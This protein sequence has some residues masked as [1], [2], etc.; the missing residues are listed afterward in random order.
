MAHEVSSVRGSF[1]F[2]IALSFA[3]KDKREKIR[4]I[5][6]MLGKRLG[7][8]KV[9]FDEYFEHEFGGLNADIY[10]Q[11]VYGKQSRLVVPCIC[12]CYSKTTWTEYE[13][14]A[15]RNF[16]SELKNDPVGRCRFFPIRV[17]EGEIEIDGLFPNIDV[18]LDV[19]DRNEEEIVKLIL[20]RHRHCKNGKPRDIP[21]PPLG[22]DLHYGKPFVNE[23][24][25]F[26]KKWRAEYI[27]S[28]NDKT[29]VNFEQTSR[30]DIFFL[31]AVLAEC[32]S[33]K[34]LSGNLLPEFSFVEK[35]PT[36]SV[37]ERV[38]FL[39]ISFGVVSERLLEIPAFLA[40]F[41]KAVFENQQ[42]T[43]VNSL[44]SVSRRIIWQTSINSSEIDSRLENRMVDIGLTPKR[45]REGLA[46]LFTSRVIGDWLERLGSEQWTTVQ[47]IVSGE[48]MPLSEIYVDLYAVPEP[49]GGYGLIRK[50]DVLKQHRSRLLSQAKREATNVVSLLHQLSRRT[51]IIGDPGSGKSTFTK[52]AVMQVLSGEIPDFRL[53]L[54]VN[55]GHL[56]REERQ[57]MC[58]TSEE[59][60]IDLLEHFVAP[61]ID[62]ADIASAARELAQYLK[63]RGDVFLILDGWDEVPSDLRDPVHL[64]IDRVNSFIP[65]IITSRP[66]G[67]PKALLGCQASIYE[68]AGLTSASAEKLVEVFFRRR[69]KPWL[70]L[71]ISDRIQKQ[72]SVFST[73][74]FLLTLQCVM[75]EQE[76]TNIVDGS[77][78][79]DRNAIYQKILELLLA[80]NR[81][82]LEPEILDKLAVLAETQS[83]SNG[84]TNGVSFTG[85]Q[86]SETLSN[87]SEAI[88]VCQSRVL[89]CLDDPFDTTPK[90]EHTYS[91]S[92]LTFGEFLAAKHIAANPDHAAIQ[93]CGLDLRRLE[94]YRFL[95]DFH[96]TRGAAEATRVLENRITAPDRYRF[97]FV[98]L[99][100]LIADKHHLVLECPW[101]NLITTQLW[102]LLC[103]EST[104]I[105]L[106]QE[107]VSLLFRINAKWFV[108]QCLE[109]P[110]AVQELARQRF[111]IEYGGRLPW[112]YLEK[113]IGP[114]KPWDAFASLADSSFK[115][116]SAFMQLTGPETTIFFQDTLERFQ[117]NHTIE[118]AQ[119]LGQMRN[120]EA[121]PS[122]VK[123]I[124]EGDPELA[125]QCVYALA[126]IKGKVAAHEIVSGLL[127]P[128]E[129]LG[130]S[131]FMNALR[132]YGMKAL[133]PDGQQRIIRRIAVS[134]PNLV[135]DYLDS[136]TGYPIR[137]GAGVIASLLVAPPSERDNDWSVITNAE[138][139]DG[140][141][142]VLRACEDIRIVESVLEAAKIE[143][144]PG[145]RAA[146]IGVA[147]EAGL[148]TAFQEWMLKEIPNQRNK[149]TVRTAL[150]SVSANYARRYPDSSFRTKLSELLVNELN[151][152]TLRSSFELLS[153][154]LNSADV[155]GVPAVAILGGFL[156]S[157]GNAAEKKYSTSEKFEVT[158]N[159]T[160]TALVRIGTEQAKSVLLNECRRL[161]RT[162]LTKREQFIRRSVLGGLVH[163]APLEVLN[164]MD[165][166]EEANAILRDWSSQ[167]GYLVF[168][169]YIFDPN[170]QPVVV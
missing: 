148:P 18:V 136:L 59:K 42:A 62:P 157:L 120:E 58:D 1:R 54:V 122:L 44:R 102:N 24:G 17:D 110:M 128:P 151:I 50:K 85:S 158:V 141:I 69:S 123:Q 166:C 139:R 29:T 163:M 138:I 107:I 155:A 64:A 115:P 22:L 130:S 100:Q 67:L 5:A 25:N 87:R 90:L 88:A 72:G 8:G 40:R 119:S 68:L 14:R 94:I 160:T 167:S 103:S 79:Q 168:D 93:K 52:W 47:G 131:P 162:P 96:G 111:V 145:I 21:T 117:L 114:G 82:R 33:G 56:R 81:V 121:V 95:L 13:W 134:P 38:K 170:G 126:T 74:P 150:L 2:E 124:K 84:A 132:S 101:C 77:F 36:E 31:F 140:A 152:L 146:L 71:E 118:D 129:A 142:R 104:P 19:Q 61:F 6:E 135:G 32:E 125:E 127:D 63:S 23:A 48:R 39:G 41:W 109:N 80:E 9:F 28:M 164:C 92:H 91:F 7:D 108:D 112:L 133:D 99:G 46:D 27:R 144:Q 161:L 147:Y 10:F 35:L 30:D 34:P 49:P 45:S 86:L 165:K 12:N 16:V 65:V 15:I 149:L 60:R 76:E 43:D 4:K 73:N 75:L 97:L 57:P 89:H 156:K 137:S 11:E 113:L 106:V 37:W 98:R 51:L 116:T 26:L 105:E 154:V 66:S 169:N 3:S 159:S 53:P 55:L 143:K 70:S 83:F 78:F 153:E 20:D